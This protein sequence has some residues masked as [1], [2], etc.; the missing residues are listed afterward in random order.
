MSS[1]IKTLRLSMASK[2]TDIR[3]T[4]EGYAPWLKFLFKDDV[5]EIVQLRFDQSMAAL[6]AHRLLGVKCRTALPIRSSSLS[7]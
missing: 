1:M 3:N 2:S 5:A 4:L 6:A 7:R